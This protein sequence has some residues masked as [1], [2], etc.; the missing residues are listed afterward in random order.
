MLPRT[1]QSTRWSTPSISRQFTT[2]MISQAGG[3]NKIKVTSKGKFK[4]HRLGGPGMEEAFDMERDLA[5]PFAMQDVPGVTHLRWFEARKRLNKLRAIKFHMPSLI[6]YQQPF[7]P[8][9][10]D[11]HV[12]LRT[13]DDLGFCRG[14]L[15]SQRA[16]KKAS[17]TVNLSKI[18]SLQSSPEAMHKIKL[19]SGNRWFECERRSEFDLSDHYGDPNG[20]IKISCDDYPSLQM[21]QKW[22]SDT[23]DRLIHEATNLSSDSMADIPLDLRPT[24]KRRH[25]IKSRPWAVNQNLQIKFPLDWLSDPIRSKL[26][27]SQESKKS[28]L[29][30]QKSQLNKL[31]NQLRDLIKWDGIGLTPTI[32]FFDNLDPATKTKVDSFVNQRHQIRDLSKHL[33]RNYLKKFISA[34]TLSDSTTTTTTTTSEINSS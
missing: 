17:I 12:I 30:E 4:D 19:L 14:K 24:L 33:D 20:Y 34:S 31:D 25:N 15:D 16:N 5:K 27:S 2:S 28:I 32:N 26:Q 23:L 6:K 11:A 29:I 8:P 3:K 18:P 9:S 1:I 22:C 21:N 13:Q 7:I 10:P